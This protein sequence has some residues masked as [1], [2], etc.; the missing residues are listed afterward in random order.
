M[1]DLKQY[2]IIH[3]ALVGINADIQNGQFDAYGL[4]NTFRY[5]IKN[6]TGNY[7]GSKLIHKLDTLMQSWPEY[8]GDPSYIIGQSGFDAAMMYGF[9]P[10][11]WQGSYSEWMWSEK[12]PYGRKRRELLVWLIN[13]C[14]E[15]TG[16]VL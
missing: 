5:K 15:I 12:S 4:C 13:R 14:E 10:P 7:V 11:Y 1:T 6:L 8:S 2:Q 3:K 16:Q 9:A